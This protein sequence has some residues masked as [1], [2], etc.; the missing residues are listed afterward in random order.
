M[1]A[2]RAVCPCLLIPYAYGLEVILNSDDKAPVLAVERFP[3]RHCAGAQTVLG[4]GAFCIS[5]LGLLVWGKQYG[6]D[7]VPQL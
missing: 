7:L 1:Q 4:F 3:Q 5:K 6:E 2:I